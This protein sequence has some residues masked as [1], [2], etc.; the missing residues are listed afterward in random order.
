MAKKLLAEIFKLRPKGIE[1]V[2]Q[3]AGRRFLSSMDRSWPAACPG[4]GNSLGVSLCGLS[5]DR[6]AAARGSNFGILS[7]FIPP[8]PPLFIQTE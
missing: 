7:A 1:R 5:L 6:Q 3:S 2:I 8:V 4:G